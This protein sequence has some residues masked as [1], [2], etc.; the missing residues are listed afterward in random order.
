MTAIARPAR[1][2]RAPAG[3]RSADRIGARAPAGS[4]RPRRRPV[5]QLVDLASV[6]GG[7]QD[8]R[9][10][11]IAKPRVLCCYVPG[12]EGIEMTRNAALLVLALVFA[13]PS[14][15]QPSFTTASLRGTYSY[16]NNNDDVASF[17]LIVF[18]G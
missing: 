3:A 12:E 9:E 16:V 10:I 15:A 5:R 17:G 11:R 18:D 1:S 6:S 13:T 7:P 4:P 14:L 2:W 8:D